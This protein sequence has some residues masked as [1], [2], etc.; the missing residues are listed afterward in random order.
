MTKFIWFCAAG[1]SFFLGAALLI[2]TIFFSV[3][4]KKVWHRLIVYALTTAGAF[5]IL[6]SAAALPLLFYVVWGAGILGW[7]FLVALPGSTK[8]K[9]CRLL[10]IFAVFLSVLALFAELPYYLE[11][12]LPKQQFQKLYI[13]GDS[14]TAGVGGKNEQTWPEILRKRYEVDIV[15]LSEPGATVGSA[16]H[17]AA[18]VTSE[19]AIVLLEIGGNDLFS[20]TPCHLFEKDLGQ[21]LK[22]VNS[23]K[24]TLIML[25]LPLLPWHIE[26]GRIQRKLAKQFDVIFVPKRFFANVL[27][28]KNAT[29]DIAHLSPSGHE[30]MAEKI[31]LLLAGRL[32]QTE[33]KNQI[34]ACAD[35]L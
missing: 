30:L 19:N 29:T 3:L 13:I 27:S 24:R 28:A 18:Q 33:V 34:S 17:Q 1:H 4:H 2:F 16:I 22:I 20:P 32:T 12:T 31:W 26:Y 6:L 25:E 10:H 23:P 11:T 5:L 35:A 7:L 9:T 21:I 14:V 8:R 15:D